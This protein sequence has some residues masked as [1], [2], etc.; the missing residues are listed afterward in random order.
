[1]GRRGRTR[2]R[3]TAVSECASVHECCSIGVRVWWWWVTGGHRMVIMTS[4]A[5]VLV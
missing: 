2:C 4:C 3:T 1:L 5:L